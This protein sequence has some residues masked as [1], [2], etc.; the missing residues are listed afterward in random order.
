MSTSVLIGYATRYGST[1]EVAEEVAT[2]LQ[3]NG[4]KADVLSMREIK[5]ISGYS[6]VVLGSP[7]FMFHLHKDVMRFLSRHR[8]ALTERPVAFFVL[9]PV[10]EPHDEQ[11]W[12]DSRNQLE[13][14]LIKFPWFTPIDLKIFGGKY[15][16][17]RLRFPLKLFAGSVPA[18]DIRDWT[19]IRNWV[20]DLSARIKPSL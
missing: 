8:K 6:A 14:E 19:V 11:E 3:E 4:F 10:H 16:P 13:K 7:L 2:A 9:G 12:K 17:S 15:D 20:R 1:R 5:T 18:S